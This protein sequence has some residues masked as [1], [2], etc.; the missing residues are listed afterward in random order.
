M[1]RNPARQLSA[2][3]LAGDGARWGELLDQ[4]DCIELTSAFLDLVRRI[5]GYDPPPVPLSE[6]R[7]TGERSFEALVDGLRS[8]SMAQE[9]TVAVDVGVSRARA[10]I[11]ITALMTAIRL[12]FTVLW[13]ALTR[14]ATA[15]DAELVVRHT[16][17]VLLTVDDYAGQ[18][19]RAY[20][21]ERARMQEEASSV[22]RGLIASVFQDPRPSTARL[23]EI[24]AELGLPGGE[25][26][27]VM[28]AADADVAPLR[29]YVA[30]LERTG[31]QTF[32]TYIGDTLVAF[33]PRAVLPGTR[34]EGVLE[35]LQDLRVGVMLAR[36]GITDLRRAAIM[37]RELS[38]IL[39]PQERGAMTWSRGWARIAAG[40]LLATG[41][42]VVEDVDRALATCGSAERARLREAVQ[43]YLRT[44]SISASSGE[45]FC[46]RN[47][48]ANRLRR[49]AEL[50]GVDP[51]I[52]EDA[53]RL[54]VGWS[55]DDALPAQ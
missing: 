45:L 16:G 31:A 15:A 22:R 41:D 35:G 10:G 32:T 7:R 3:P 14:V 20:V 34:T 55:S 53:A 46:H 2:T 9:L 28:A 26:L 1:D 50:T 38:R 17:I 12:D 13:D 47:T 11:P 48:L 39:R 8:G 6:V 23:R 30:E 29:V 51:L 40:R 27:V 37:A 52:P 42:P 24:G 33:T 49:F 25:P 5:P 44:G 43:S 36:S 19:Q 54:V 18:T 4:L 21:E